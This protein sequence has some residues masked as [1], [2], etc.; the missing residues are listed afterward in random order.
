MHAEVPIIGQEKDFS[1]GSATLMATLL[2][3]L[4]DA[5][6]VDRES[7]LWGALK[8]DPDVGAEP[9]AMVAVAQSL[10]L[11]AI[12]VLDLTLDDLRECLSSGITPILCLQAWKKG[13]LR[14]L[15][16]YDDGHWVNLVGMDDKFAYIM[17]PWLA[18][19]E[20]AYGT[21]P[22]DQL[23]IRWHNPDDHGMP[24]EH[25]AVL[26]RGDHPAQPAPPAPVQPV[27]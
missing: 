5:T 26:I 17:D 25:M 2:Y 23:D 19:T 4:G 22:L 7:E 1:C 21:I 27:P 20:K 24:Q 6:P 3:W 14:Y 9:E 18:R 11:D 15:V 13:S 10:G 16:D 8:I 12:P